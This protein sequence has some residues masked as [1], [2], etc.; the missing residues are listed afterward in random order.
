VREGP[1][2]GTARSRNTT[3]SRLPKSAIAVRG[4]SFTGEA[5]DL[6]QFEP[7]LENRKASLGDLSGE[8]L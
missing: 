4:Q 6:F 3:W 1:R 7:V 2:D 8:R 5:L